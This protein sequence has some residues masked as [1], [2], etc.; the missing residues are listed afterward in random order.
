MMMMMMMMM[1]PT[2]SVRNSYGIPNPTINYRECGLE[3][4]SFVCDPS[5]VLSDQARYD[6]AVLTDAIKD[7]I[8]DEDCGVDKGFQVAVI[9][10]DHTQTRAFSTAENCVEGARNLMDDFGV[11]ERG[12]NNGV[13]LLLALDDRKFAIFAGAG[14]QKHLPSSVRNRILNG[15]KNDLRA[16]RVDAAVLEAVVQIRDALMTM[17]TFWDQYGET[18]V[19]CVFIGVIIAIIA[20]FS[21]CAYI[22]E[23]RR[24]RRVREVRSL[25]KRIDNTKNE[26]DAMTKAERFGAKTCPI[27]LENFDSMPNQ[28]LLQ[29]GH[30]LCT[31]C[32]TQ[33]FGKTNMT[34]TKRLTYALSKT[35]HH[36]C[37]VCRQSCMF[38]KDHKT[39]ETT[40]LIPPVST[41]TTNRN[42]TTQDDNNYFK[43]DMTTSHYQDLRRHR[44][45]SVR[46]RYRDL[47]TPSQIDTWILSSQSN[48]D[49]RAEREWHAAYERAER[50]RRIAASHRSSNS[51]SS[52]SFGGGSSFGG[53]G[54]G[55]GW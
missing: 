49:F 39:S 15:M 5:R 16:N 21:L 37:P 9:I 28:T 26:E 3:A 33:W 27:C 12:C 24:K 45:M 30:K 44:Y 46:R 51:S 40:P 43:D 53:S 41:T 55:G 13:V 54:S 20:C 11:G 18:V 1:V 19:F 35:P 38:K 42:T 29:C 22:Q 7:G 8:K 50:A 6:L 48:S 10:S 36:R 47:V 25:L 34:K 14:A 23:R 17:P 52:S 2:E 4:P 32:A 31:P